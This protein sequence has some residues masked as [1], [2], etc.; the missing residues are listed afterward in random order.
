MALIEPFLDSKFHIM[1]R[2]YKS[3]EREM[4]LKGDAMHLFLYKKNYEK[5][6]KTLKN[7]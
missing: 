5:K 2:Q 6:K 4:Q 3:N 7:I 1:K